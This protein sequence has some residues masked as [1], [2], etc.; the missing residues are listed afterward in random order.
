MFAKSAGRSGH[1]SILLAS[2]LSLCSSLHSDG[3]VMGKAATIAAFRGTS[4]H[5]TS[6]SLPGTAVERLSAARDRARSLSGKLTG[7]WAS[8]RKDLL[9]AAGLAAVQQTSHCFNDYNHVSATTMAEHVQANEHDGQVEGMERG[10]QLGPEIKS[11][12]LHDGEGFE[13][14]GSW[15]TCAL[16]AGKAPPFDVAHHQFQS[17]V[18]F[19]LLWVNGGD[20]FA[21]ATEEGETLACGQP[22]GQLPSAYER[23]KNWQI[24]TKFG[25]SKLAKA[26]L[27]CG[28]ANPDSGAKSSSHWG[29]LACLAFFASFSAA[30]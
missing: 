25:E 28:S 4:W 27:E 21:L 9:W 10:N 15:C 30:F 26:A 7:D 6:R 24:F 11:A 19:Y 1:L 8:I 16:G 2:G 18:A 22:K 14:D 12:S 5:S 17:E 23:K 3:D 13:K 20:Q 29:L